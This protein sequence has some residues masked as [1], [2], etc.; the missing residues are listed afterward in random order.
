[1][2]KEEVTKVDTEEGGKKE[3]KR[4][5]MKDGKMHFNKQH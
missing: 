4:D 3:K 5:R 1:M 2:E